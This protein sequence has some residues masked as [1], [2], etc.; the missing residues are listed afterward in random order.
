MVV[1]LSEATF[2][3][4]KHTNKH[5]GPFGG[6]LASWGSTALDGFLRYAPDFYD[7]VPKVAHKL[8]TAGKKHRHREH[9]YDYDHYEDD[10]PL[11]TA[12]KRT[13]KRIN[14][15]LNKPHGGHVVPVYPAYHGYGEHFGGFDHFGGGFG[16]YEHYPLVIP[17]GSFDELPVHGV[18]HDSIDFSP[19]TFGNSL[20]SHDLHNFDHGYHL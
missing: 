20:Y 12:G 13:M 4:H 17:H 3:R 7:V 19:H 6:H 16:G 8:L 1:H 2:G 11:I 9:Y 15:L 14:K 5:K 18:F 10:H